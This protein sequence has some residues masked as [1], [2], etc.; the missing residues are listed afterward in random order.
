MRTGYPEQAALNLRLPRS[1][2]YRLKHPAQRAVAQRLRAL[3]PVPKC[4]LQMTSGVHPIPTV[5]GMTGEGRRDRSE[6]GRRPAPQRND[7]EGHADSQQHFG[8]A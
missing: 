6:T 5:G 4:T 8:R 7:E 3:P 1:Q 2:L